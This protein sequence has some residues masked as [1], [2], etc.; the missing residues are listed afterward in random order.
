MKKADEL[1]IELEAVG[2]RLYVN[3]NNPT[4]KEVY[5]CCGYMEDGQAYF[6]EK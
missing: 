2:I 4:A 5:N 6:M 1:K 3:A